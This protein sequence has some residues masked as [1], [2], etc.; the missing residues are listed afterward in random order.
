MFGGGEWGFFGGF[1]VAGRWLGKGYSA[2]A[3]RVE[4]RRRGKRDK[5]S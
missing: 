4:R 2:A 1:L 3:C 5:L